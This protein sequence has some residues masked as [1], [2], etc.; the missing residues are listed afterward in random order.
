[1]R[2]H[3]RQP[4][5]ARSA[6]P[7]DRAPRRRALTGGPRPRPDRPAGD[8]AAPG[9]RCRTSRR[10]RHRPA[11]AHTAAGAASGATPCVSE[12][13]PCAERSGPSSSPGA[14]WRHWSA[15]S[16]TR[17]GSESGQRIRAS[18]SDSKRLLAEQELRALRNER[19][20]LFK[21][22]LSLL[23]P[24][25]CTLEKSK[26]IHSTISNST[27]HRCAHTRP[28]AE[29][30]ASVPFVTNVR[31]DELS[32]QKVERLIISPECGLLYLIHRCGKPS[33]VFTFAQPPATRDSTTLSHIM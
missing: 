18:S 13:T 14:A 10:R 27:H 19:V 3:Q 15:S 12:T 1:M 32:D 26:K 28:L 20:L 6:Q 33:Q 17:S 5:H 22:S 24:E 23:L 16:Q 9:L 29:K 2:N 30:I 31:L 8:H 7:P 25:E 21:K 4:A 11:A